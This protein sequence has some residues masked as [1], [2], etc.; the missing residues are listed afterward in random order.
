MKLVMKSGAPTASQIKAAMEYEREHGSGSDREKERK[1][2]NH[3]SER[4][5]YYVELERMLDVPMH[6]K[7]GDGMAYR[8][9]RA[10][11]YSADEADQLAGKMGGGPFI[12][13]KGGKW[14]DPQFTIPWQEGGQ[15]QQ[16]AGEQPPKGQPPAG[17][18]QP[19]A[20]PK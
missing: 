13:P 1:V 15:P 20:Q 19:A 3:L 7:S 8:S 5:T 9:Y 6:A 10:Q 16:S 2:V 12:G 11:G 4:P 18:Q 14:A 17:P